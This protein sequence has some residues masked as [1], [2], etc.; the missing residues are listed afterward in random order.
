M[1]GLVCALSFVRA[2]HASPAGAA[3]AYAAIAATLKP[4]GFERSMGGFFVAASDDLA[5]AHQ[6]IEALRGLEWFAQSVDSVR[7]FRI[8]AWSDFTPILRPSR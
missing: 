6:A 7:V 3:G 2:E 4:F 1:L 8:D 5:Q